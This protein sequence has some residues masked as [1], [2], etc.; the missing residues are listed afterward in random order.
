MKFNLLNQQRLISIIVGGFLLLNISGCNK[1]TAVFEN[2]D[3]NRSKNDITTDSNVPSLNE[4]LPIFLTEEQNSQIEWRETVR[5]NGCCKYLEVHVI[6]PALSTEKIIYEYPF[7]RCD[8]CSGR[9]ELEQAEYNK[10]NQKQYKYPNHKNT[11]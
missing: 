5:D 9:E 11:Y 8:K 7:E 10:V 6:I 1:K 2:D 3:L 4:P